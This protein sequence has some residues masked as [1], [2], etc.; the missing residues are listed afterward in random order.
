MAHG[1]LTHKGVKIIPGMDRGFHE[2]VVF[3]SGDDYG[4]FDMT[5]RNEP[6]DWYGRVTATIRLSQLSD[7]IQT[8]KE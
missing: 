8:F 5:H 6:D 3:E 2:M 4:L 7:F 1:E